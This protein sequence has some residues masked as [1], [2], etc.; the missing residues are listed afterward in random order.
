M[1]VRKFYPSLDP[2]SI[3]EP[4]HEAGLIIKMLE[5][6]L[7]TN[8]GGKIAFGLKCVEVTVVAKESIMCRSPK[9][10][11]GIG[12]NKQFAIRCFR[13]RGLVEPPSISQ[14]LQQ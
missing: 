8:L 11:L 2:T 14:R 9:I 10:G 6:C 7:D 12:H 1:S 4:E 3:I 13:F 5:M